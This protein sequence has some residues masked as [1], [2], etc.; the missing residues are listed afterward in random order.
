MIVTK[1][2]KKTTG[3]DNKK[4]EMYAATT[5]VTQSLFL[6]TKQQVYDGE[7]NGSH[8]SYCISCDIGK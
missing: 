8:R 1:V 3:E 6:M 5:T 4:T 2:L 7:S